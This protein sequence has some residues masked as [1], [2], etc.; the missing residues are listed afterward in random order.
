MLVERTGANEKYTT[1]KYK[2]AYSVHKLK[3]LNTFLER[4]NI[5]EDV[6]FLKETRYILPFFLKEIRKDKFS[7][8]QIILNSSMLDVV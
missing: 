4:G 5:F 7:Y 3:V 6:G 8:I 2:R 1:K